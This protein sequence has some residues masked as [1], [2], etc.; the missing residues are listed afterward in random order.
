MAI[1]SINGWVIGYFR[2]NPII[3]TLVTAAL[4]DGFIRW[5]FSNKQAYPDKSSAAGAAFEKLFG[6][7]LFG[8]LPLTLAILGA[9]LVVGHV[10]RSNTKFGTQLKL[11]GSSYEVARM[12]GLPTRRITFYVFLLSSFCSSIAGILLAS[13]NKVGASYIGKGYDFMAVTAIVIGGV[14]MAGGR[15]NVAGVLGG[16]LAIGLMGKIMTLNGF[17]TFEQEVVQGIVFVLVV[18][19]SAL[20]AR[21]AG[22]DDA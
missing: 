7:S 21:R 15:G 5:A 1:G 8:F 2:A 13:L 16:V 11:Q 19:I 10:L 4:G 3:W 18:G 22:R 20:M 14:T 12:T 17:G 9:L 6:M